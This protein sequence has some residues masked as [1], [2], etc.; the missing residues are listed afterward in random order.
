MRF[1]AQVLDLVYDSYDDFIV[2]LDYILVV[3]L[4]KLL[5]KVEHGNC[6]QVLKEAHDIRRENEAEE[7]K[8]QQVLERTSHEHK[9]HGA[10]S[11]YQCKNYD[12]DENPQSE[13]GC[14][15]RRIHQFSR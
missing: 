3:P 13:A 4:Q 7:R 11:A 8:V 1:E 12:R 10:V 6:Q 9:E 15:F 14:V 2:E 5:H